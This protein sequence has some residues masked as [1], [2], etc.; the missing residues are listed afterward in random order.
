LG[1]G[2]WVAGVDNM[3]DVVGG[4]VWVGFLCLLGGAWHIYTVPF[5]WVR[6][7]FVWSGEAYLSY[8]LAAI[9]LMGIVAALFVWYNNTA[10][11]SEF[12]GPTGPEASQAQAFTFL[13]RDQLLGASV[14]SSQGP[15][16]LG[17]YLMRS[18]SGEIIFGGETMRFWDMRSPWV[19]PLRGPNG[20]EISKIRSDI[21]PWQV[22]RAAEY[23]THAPLG[24]LNSVG[25]VATEVNSVNYVSPRSWLTTSHFFL[26]FF[27]WVGHI[28]HAGRSRSS[29]IGTEKGINR[30]LEPALFMRMLD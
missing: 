26:G 5:G 20:L 9:S 13:F 4:H 24:S 6:R 3:E 11:P 28:W 7:A 21:Q 1:G 22:R 8:S 10:Y 17:K 16:G 29:G 27:F 12:Y 19:E 14:A 15:T 18:P 30:L 23:M 2:G 25:G